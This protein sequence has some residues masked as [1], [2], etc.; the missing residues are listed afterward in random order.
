M[1][2]MMESSGSQH[3]FACQSTVAMSGNT[4]FFF[5]ARIRG[6]HWHLRR[7]EVKHLTMYNIA[8]QQITIQFLK[9]VLLGM[10]NQDIKEM[11]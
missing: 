11:L 6:C 8:P 5:N 3:D 9:S 7:V 10:R 4:F 2:M 1:M